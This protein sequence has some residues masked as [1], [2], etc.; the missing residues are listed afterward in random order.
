MARDRDEEQEWNAARETAGALRMGAGLWLLAYGTH[1]F[2][3]VARE[4]FFATRMHPANWRFIPYWLNAPAIEDGASQAV[5]FPSA[6]VPGR[7]LIAI[8]F[9]AA[10]LFAL[11]CAVLG[12]VRRKN[13]PAWPGKTLV[14]AGFA[15]LGVSI[16]AHVLLRMQVSVSFIVRGFSVLAMLEAALGLVAA[17]HLRA[18]L[19]D[20]GDRWLTR[21]LDPLL[22][23]AAA[24]VAMRGIDLFLRAGDAALMVNYI[25]KAACIATGLGFVVVM[26]RLWTQPPARLEP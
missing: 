8:A 10:A 5:Y 7:I 23:S 16:V 12:S 3:V 21:P 14:V 18:I 25:L 4:L 20:A 13:H 2:A 22:W 17:F 11:S 6:Q 1:L 15:L 19:R 9:V 26:M 24:V